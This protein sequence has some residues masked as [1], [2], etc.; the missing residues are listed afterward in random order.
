MESINDFIIIDQA[1]IQKQSELLNLETIIEN[2]LQNP[3]DNPE[4]IKQITNNIV[5]DHTLTKDFY[6]YDKITTQKEK[7]T[8][9][10][11]NNL[12]RVIVYKPNNNVTIKKYILTNGILQN[13]SISFDIETN[14]YQTTEILQN[15]YEVSVIVY[16]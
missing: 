14:K 9:S 6:V 4:I 11:L 8:L 3:E 5:Y 10:E 12:S 15:N 16:S 13:K 1:K 2:S 7:L